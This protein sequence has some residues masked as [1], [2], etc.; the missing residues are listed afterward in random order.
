MWEKLRSD[1][2]F[3]YSCL[4]GPK[5]CEVLDYQANPCEAIHDGNEAGREHNPER[6]VVVWIIM[7]SLF[8]KF[9]PKRRT[10]RIALSNIV[11]GGG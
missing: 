8:L 7:A 1:D 11:F 3:L 4:L 5:R 6:H 10:L 9:C 2:R